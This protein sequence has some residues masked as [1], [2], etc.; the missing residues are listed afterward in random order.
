MVK[1]NGNI[2]VM[3]HFA[4]SAIHGLRRTQEAGTDETV[5]A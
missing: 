2:V 4:L 3:S 5:G 1:G